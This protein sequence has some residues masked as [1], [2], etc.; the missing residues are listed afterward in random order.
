MMIQNTLVYVGTYTEPIR[1][2]TGKVLHGK[3][4]GIYRFRLDQE[5]GALEP[6]GITTGVANPSYLAFDATQRFLYAVNELKSYQDRPTGTVSAF[7]VDAAS[8]A[9]TFLN[10]QPT[11]GTDPCHVVVDRQR[12]HVFVANFM[13]GSVCVL[14]LRADG[15]LDAA[16][17][18]VQHLGS[19]IDPARQT[20]PHAHSVTLDKTGR[21]ALVPDLG[22][23][24]LL[25]YQFDATRG[26]LEP[27]VVPWIKLPPGAGPRHVALHPG[28]RFAYLINELNSTVA[29]LAWDRKARGFRALQL[30]ST[31]PEGFDGANSGADIHVAASGRFV[32]ASNRGHDSIATYR[33]DARSGGLSLV[34]HAATQ[35]RTP[36][37]FCLDPTGR[38][39][40]V[41]NQD[42]DSIVTFRIDARSGTLTPTGHVAPVPTPVCVTCRRAATPNGGDAWHR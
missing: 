26:M 12:R 41:A 9:L 40:L 15:S 7:A 14:K 25:I 18:F 24:K 17:D 21:Y 16:C 39:A 19:G 8:G 28:G 36:R 11:H 30:V 5:S 27:G 20:G 4:E 6:A 33:I 22:L 38:F 37:S 42:S 10:R 29:A 23:D 35:G 13:S 2:G 3:G 31:L 1:F 32:Y 34:G